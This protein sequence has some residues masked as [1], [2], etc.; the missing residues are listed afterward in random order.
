MPILPVPGGG[1]ATL[2]SPYY[3]SLTPNHGEYQF[4]ALSEI[5]TN[6][7]ATYVGDGKILESVLTADI[8]FHAYR[9]LQELSYDT[10]KSIKSQEIIVPATLQMIL[11][12]DYVN[13]TKI[14]WVDFSGIKHILYP[15]SKTSNPKK[16]NQ[17]PNG[18]YQMIGSD[19][20]VAS[21]STSW[22]SYKAGGTS[23]VKD[24]KYWTFEDSRY[25]LDP[26]YAQANGSFYIDEQSGKIHF[27]SNIS[28]KTVILDYI[29]DGVGTLDEAI[30]HKFAE[31]AMYKWIAHGCAAARKDSPEYL[32][33]R[34]K[35]ERF[36][37][38]RKAKIRLSNIKIEEI[39]QIVRGMS[40]WI[41]H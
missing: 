24:D 18:D 32:I 10:F 36:A 31:E 37:E 14:S 2:P 3:T 20:S 29:S 4:I 27:S 35:K 38:T 17:D 1:G 30:V 25:G 13:Y 8:T 5:I 22:T 6:F 40:K 28:G 41:K 19:L 7:Q 15:A 16:I 21:Q 26:Q 34:L 11:P 12:H 33:A 9:A 23:E 39:S